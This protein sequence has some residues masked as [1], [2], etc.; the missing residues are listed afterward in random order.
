MYMVNARQLAS[1]TRSVSMVR[2]SA[3]FII[4]ASVGLLFLV[5]TLATKKL[6]SRLYMVMDGLRQVKDGNLYTAILVPG[7]DEVAEMA[8]LFSDMVVQLR[9]LIEEIKKEHELLAQTE[10][11]AMQNQINAHF[12][13]NALETIKM[14][15]ELV[16]K[17][18]LVDS[19]TILGRLMR[20]SLKLNKHQVPLEQELEYIQGYISFMNIRNDYH[21]DLLLH[22]PEAFRGIEIPKMLIQ[23]IVENAVKHGIEVEGEDAAI[24][25]SVSAEPDSGRWW[26]LIQDSGVG[27]DEGCLKELLE[28]IYGCLETQGASGGIGLINIQQRLFSFYGKE[29]R[30]VLESRPGQGTT[31]AI[32]LPLP[33]RIENKASL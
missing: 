23:P 20:Y 24:S 33:D 19:I 31:V 16:N 22:I 30:L 17:K 26:I 8:H 27:M 21:I 7:H 2:F 32:P 1:V 9:S 18:S 25:I 29:F 3:F 5:I 15:A 13:Y 6:V 14:Q 4:F 28:R 10:I 11:K 12:L